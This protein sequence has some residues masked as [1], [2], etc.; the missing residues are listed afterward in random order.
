MSLPQ[1]PIRL[2]MVGGGQDA[3]I[4]AVHRHAAA[5]DGR[6]VLVAGALSSTPERSRASGAALGLPAERSY[7]TWQD[8]LA[9]ER[10]REDG[11]EIISIVTPNHLHFPVALAAVQAGFHVICDKP[12]VPTLDEARQ[13]EAAVKQAGV[14]FAVTY[15]YSGYPM[16]RQAREMV[17]GGRLGD[18]RKV[19]VEY[20][21]GWLAT[22][23]TG[24]QAEWRTDPARNGPAGAL[25]DIGS[26]AEQL[27]T[28]VSGL[29]LDQVAAEL[30]AFVP[31]RPL[32][33]D[34]SMLLRFEGGARGVLTVSQ[35]EIG[36]ENDLRLSVFGS[37]GSLSWRQED[38][39]H[40]VYDQLDTARQILT[41]GGPGTGEAAG[42]MTRLPAGHP[43]AFIEAFANIYRAV[44]DDLAAR[45]QGENIPPDYPTVRDGVQG[46]AFMTRVLESA[47][48]GGVWVSFKGR[49]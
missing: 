37:A 20:H 2:A 40:L 11:A 24:K 12:L 3:F 6:Y 32:D 10:Q 31:G 8:L 49:T 36:R 33:D 23:Q 47:A 39:N 35:I 19:I 25:G 46:V 15:N 22:R 14:A 34:A 43:E 18:V 13:L 45:E 42:A 9:G 29:A 41:R 5:L 4:G 17:R 7:G 16:I 26:H 48:G 21:Q 28:F 30:T 38:P 27:A 1:R 44:A